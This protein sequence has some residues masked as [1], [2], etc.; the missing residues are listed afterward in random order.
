MRHDISRG[1][2]EPQGKFSPEMNIELPDLPEIYKYDH[3]FSRIRE[4]F[5][6][7]MNS[8]QSCFKTQVANMEKQ[9]KSEMDKLQADKEK[10]QENHQFSQEQISKQF[11]SLTKYRQ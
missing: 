11:D 9:F 8:F 1:D 3:N 6:Q 7:A 4:A 10:L 5:T 2:L